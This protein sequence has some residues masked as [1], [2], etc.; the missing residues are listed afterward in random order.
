M[1]QSF[2]A[3]GEKDNDGTE[4]NMKSREWIFAVF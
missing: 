3:E 4:L 2:C 1:T